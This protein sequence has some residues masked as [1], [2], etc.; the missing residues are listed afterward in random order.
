MHPYRFKS[1]LKFIEY[2]QQLQL[3]KLSFF[4]SVTFE[5][6][7]HFV[8][9]SLNHASLILFSEVLYCLL[10]FEITLKSF[11]ERLH[12]FIRDLFHCFII[13]IDLDRF[14]GYNNLRFCHFYSKLPL[15]YCLFAFR[16]HFGMPFH[17]IS[18]Y[19]KNL[20]F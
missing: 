15:R 6:P 12:L 11:F 17:S 7:H 8:A 10:N 9:K 2:P 5:N 13:L 18:L 3:I 19:F 16:D 1:L 14:V 4:S 20:S